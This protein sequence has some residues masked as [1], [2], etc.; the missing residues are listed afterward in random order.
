MTN[1]DPNSIVSR[2]VRQLKP[3]RQSLAAEDIVQRAITIQ[4]IPAPTFEEQQRTAYMKSQFVALDLQN[5]TSDAV[6][7]V[8]GWLTNQADTIGQETSVVVVAAH[9]DTVFPLN[10]NLS[11]RRDKNRVYGPGLGDNSLGASAML[12]LAE[13]FKQR[14]HTIPENIAICFVA[15]TREEGLGNLDGM[16][17]VLK[18]IS[19]Q[20]IGAAII[21]E[22]LALGRVYHS[23]I[24]VRRL[25]LAVKTDGGH[26]WLHFGQASAIHTIAQIIAEITMVEVPTLPRTTYNIGVI[27]GGHSVNSIATDAHCYIDLRSETPQE[28]QALEERIVGICTHYRKDDIQ[29]E[30]EVVGD[31]PAGTISPQ[32]PLV[33]LALQTLSAIGLSGILESGS[34]DANIFLAANVPT[35]V[36]GVTYGGNAHRL[37]EFIDLSLVEKGM[38]QLVLLLA[39]TLE[40]LKTNSPVS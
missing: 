35:I 1:I 19:P 34:T 8:Y 36:T 17:A 33:Q 5:V 23:G 15:N 20:K 27:E 24:A 26:S 4:Q 31:R 3:I 21:I 32:H 7:N 28:L 25:R 37:D 9:L 13:I 6:D 29:I 14:R 40:K 10:T 11:T 39:A 16:R 12:H 2:L 30:I 22:G 38:W 18:A